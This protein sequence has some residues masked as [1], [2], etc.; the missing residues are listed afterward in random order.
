MRLRKV[1]ETA[2]EENRPVNDVALDRFGSLEA[3][4]EAKEERRILDEREGRRASRARGDDSSQSKN[5]GEQRYM[6]S[7]VGTAALA[8]RGA[9]FRRPGTQE[10]S[11]PSTPVSR[12]SLPP[13]NKRLDSLR[14]PSEAAS[15]ATAH[16]TLTPIPSVMTP[17]VAGPSKTLALSTSELNKLQARVLKAKL[18]GNPDAAQLEKEYEAELVKARHGDLVENEKGKMIKVEVLPTLDARGQLYDVGQGKNEQPVL[19][20]NRKKKEK[21]TSFILLLSVPY[22]SNFSSIFSS[23]RETLKLEILYAT[24]PTTIAPL[25]E[26]C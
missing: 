5:V 1:Y 7:D 4:E 10:R 23:K 13:T 15:P 24:M 25:L 2:E 17:P 11:G 12:G 18:M 20:G 22:M 26:I 16:S 14:L 3:F 21:V 19:P 9:S 6:F 8:S